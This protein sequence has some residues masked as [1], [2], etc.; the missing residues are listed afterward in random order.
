MGYIFK[1]VYQQFRFQYLAP[2]GMQKR[3]QLMESVFESMPQLVLQSIFLIR[4]Y[5]TELAESDSNYIV[6][7]S[8]IASLLSIVTKFLTDDRQWV[9]ERARNL[10]ISHKRCPCVSFS[11]L[12]VVF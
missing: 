5:N 7:A 6:F 12:T 11:Y 9:V 3:L 4:T 8:I 1:L 10:N 2:C